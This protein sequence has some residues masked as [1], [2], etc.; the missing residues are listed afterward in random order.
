MQL[1][2][3]CLLVQFHPV[4]SDTGNKSNM[5]IWI[6]MNKNEYSS[7]RMSDLNIYGNQWKYFCEFDMCRERI[8]LRSDVVSY[9]LIFANLHV[10]FYMIVNERN[11]TNSFRPVS[12]ESH[13]CCFPFYFTN[14]AVMFNLLRWLTVKS[15]FNGWLCLSY[16]L[17]FI[18]LEICFIPSSVTHT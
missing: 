3:M 14:V 15:N 8:L 4:V 11:M 12:N 18:T 1:D 9:Q 7:V 10:L 13:F 16:V 5:K 6:F 2:S 17:W